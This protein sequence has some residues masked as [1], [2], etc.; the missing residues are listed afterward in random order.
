MKRLG[1]DDYVVFGVGAHPMVV[2][3]Q[4][5]HASL[6]RRSDLAIGE[7]HSGFLC[8]ATYLLAFISRLYLGPLELI[9]SLLTT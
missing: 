6:Y 7:V 2:E 9:H 1:H 3:I 8:S 4:T 5:I